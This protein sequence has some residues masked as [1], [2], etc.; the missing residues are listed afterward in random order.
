MVSDKLK[1]GIV[2]IINELLIDFN[3]ML[4]DLHPYLHGEALDPGGVKQ[5]L[6]D[7]LEKISQLNEKTNLTHQ[8]ISGVICSIHSSR[9]ELK[10]SVDG[11]LQQTGNQLKKITSTTQNATMQI[12]DVAS[13]LDNDQNAILEKIEALVAKTLL[14]ED[15]TVLEEIKNIVLDNQ[16]AVF[17][18]YNHL[19][20]QDITAQQIAGAYSLIA[21][22]EKTLLY[23]LNI[24][25]EF[26][27]G[28]NNPD[29]LIPNIDKN[30]FN[31][32]AVYGDNT[33]L[34]NVITDLFKT[35]NANLDLPENK[36]DTDS[37]HFAETPSE[38][39]QTNEDFDIDALFNNK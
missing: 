32:D 16:N 14:T 26:D 10:Q 19:Q 1:M 5:H 7:L 21:D 12:M 22:T 24:L 15:K 20:F 38:Q 17:D 34:Q 39:E 31:A 28:D 6:D 33:D 37:I 4:K 11:L 9:K 3:V 35:H 23:V 27:F 18:I 2:T 25:K 8:L 13:K 29:D 36:T 30:A